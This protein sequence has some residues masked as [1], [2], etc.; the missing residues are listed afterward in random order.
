MCAYS[1]FCWNTSKTIVFAFVF[2]RKYLKDDWVLDGGAGKEQPTQDHPLHIQSGSQLLFWVKRRTCLLHFPLNTLS[3]Y[4]S[5][6]FWK[7][8]VIL[9]FH[10]HHKRPLCLL[11]APQ[12]FLPLNSL[13]LPQQS[14]ENL[15]HSSSQRVVRM[16]QNCEHLKGRCSGAT[17]QVS[18]G[19]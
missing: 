6:L 12:H 8:K 10:W 11:L 18:A 7:D 19:S 5:T 16:M 1:E 2:V 4:P 9:Y 3:T 14:Y 17:V 15:W 13:H